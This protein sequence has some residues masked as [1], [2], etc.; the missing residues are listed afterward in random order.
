MHAKSLFA[1]HGVRVVA[2]AYCCEVV[3]FAYPAAQPEPNMDA[4]AHL[5]Q[6]KPGEVLVTGRNLAAITSKKNW[7]RLVSA[8]V[9][10][11]FRV[12]GG[13]SYECQSIDN[14]VTIGNSCLTVCMRPES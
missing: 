4:S 7:V 14:C 1:I 2:I 10:A 5:R 11:S 9:E 3:F 6:S 12:G 13:L 8:P